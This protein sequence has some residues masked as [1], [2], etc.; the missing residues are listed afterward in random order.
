MDKYE[1][2]D[3]LRE[4]YPNLRLSLPWPHKDNEAIYWGEPTIND[5]VLFSNTLRYCS[6]MLNIASTVSI[7]AAI[8]NTPVVC[9]GFHPA[10]KNEGEF[11]KDVHFSEHYTP[12]METGATPLSIS[13]EELIT[14]VCEQLVLQGKFEQQRHLLTDSFLPE[15]IKYSTETIIDLFN[16]GFNQ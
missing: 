13:L 15:T 11:Y 10:K 14:M 6:V 4:K 9:V 7:D 2:W 5:L 3:T 8:T 1:R 16:N 12:I